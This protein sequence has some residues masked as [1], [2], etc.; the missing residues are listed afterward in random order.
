VFHPLCPLQP[1]PH[2]FHGKIDETGR[3]HLQSVLHTHTHL[4][5]LTA[6]FHFHENQELFSQIRCTVISTLYTS[7]RTHDVYSF[8]II[9]HIQIR[10]YTWKQRRQTMIISTVARNCHRSSQIVTSNKYELLAQFEQRFQY[11][12]YISWI[13]HRALILWVIE[14]I[15]LQK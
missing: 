1:A 10:H 15:I 2:Q 11:I 3:S 5:S 8:I 7:D 14:T 12:T 4:M 6:Q 9:I 13:V